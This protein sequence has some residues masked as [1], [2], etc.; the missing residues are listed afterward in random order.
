MSFGAALS[1]LNAASADLGVIANNIA[2]ASTT[3]FKKSRAEFADVYAVSSTGTAA[4][5]IGTGTRVASVTQQ[6]TQGTVAFTDNS[7]DLAINGGGFFTL[8]DNGSTVYSRAGTF[9]VDRDGYISNNLGQRLVAFQADSTGSITGA[10]G[11]LQLDTSNIP[12]LATSKVKEVV[13]LDA[14]DSVPYAPVAST[15]ILLSSTGAN[16]VLDPDASPTTIDLNTR[17]TNPVDN[18]LVDSYGN[19]H[20]PSQLRF[21]DDGAGNWDVELLVN[22]TAVDTQT[23][24]QTPAAGDSVTF[25]W[26]PGTGADPLSITM[27]VS[28]ITT[29]TTAGTDNT[30]ISS[31]VDGALQGAFDPD[32][33]SSYNNATSLTVYDSLG[34][35]QLATT[36]YRMTGTPNVWEVYMYLGDTPINTSRQSAGDPFI[37]TFNGDGNLSALNDGSGNPDGEYAVPPGSTET[38]TVDPGSGAS[39]IELTFDFSEITQY[40]ADFSVFSLT[41]DG[42]T[43]GRLSGLDIS[44]TGVVF[45]RYTNGQ[46]QALGQVALSNFANP[47]GL[48]QLGDTLWGESYDSGAPVTGAPGTGSLGLIQ[49]GALE[50]SNVDISAELVNMITAQRNFQ[51]N[52]QVIRANDTVT[53]AII[54]IR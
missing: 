8:N 22:G 3:G 17:G 25:S 51:A 37:M 7:L 19:S 34:T 15:E 5:A 10:K 42:Y 32:N 18:Y 30:D 4:N 39:N 36:Y 43:T 28:S 6:F 23:F 52:A 54:N 21:T 12:P 16:P 38:L 31:E 1:G 14:A 9:Q 46:A 53:Q 47:Q 29:D 13:N 45:A 41:Q 24:S 11:D 40:G 2:N 50:G 44:D 20:G 48:R 49:S 26:D 35:A 33:P 27:D